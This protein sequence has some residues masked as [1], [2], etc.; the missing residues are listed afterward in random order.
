M[1]VRRRRLPL[2]ATAGGLLA[3]SNLVVPHLPPQPGIRAVVNVA[4]AAGLLVA[5]RAA[6]LTWAELGLGRSAWRAGARWG[7]AALAVG[8]AGYLVA[9]A[10][11]AT[12]SV[13]AGS[14]VAGPTGGELALRALVLIPVGVVVCEEVAFRGVLLA[15]ARRQLPVHAAVVVTSVVFGLW[16]VATALGGTRLALPPAVASLSVAGTVV[17]TGLGGALFA[18]LRVRTG[19]LLAPVGLHLAT[20]SLGLLAAAVAAR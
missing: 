20:N 2:L 17:V 9:L 15:V 5:A 18:W 4:A 19:S 16:H 1:R 7:G 10:V 11:P 12:R 8:A 6:G 13:L 14:A 3:W